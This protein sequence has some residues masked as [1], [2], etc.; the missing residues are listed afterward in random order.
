MWKTRKRC[1]MLPTIS[2]G[3]TLAQIGSMWMEIKRGKY[4]RRN[5]DGRKLPRRRYTMV[6]VE[7]AE[8]LII[9]RKCKTWR[10][11][12]WCCQGYNSYFK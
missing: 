7:K 5:L 11:T 1:P 6:P 9:P 3:K 2:K 4:E 12:N 10:K 8:R